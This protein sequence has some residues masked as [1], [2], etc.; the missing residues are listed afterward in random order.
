[1][2]PFSFSF[3]T[4]IQPI[5]I[6]TKS[7]HLSSPLLSRPTA[8]LLVPWIITA[9]LHMA[10]LLPHLA[11]SVTHIKYIDRI[12]PL[13]KLI[14]VFLSH[15]RMTHW[16]LPGMH[17][18]GHRVPTVHKA[19]GLALTSSPA[20][21][22]LYSSENCRKDMT[23]PFTREVEVAQKCM[24]RCPASLGIEEKQNEM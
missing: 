20:I 11:A 23:G 9:S 5:R 17:H 10:S 22:C 18:G 14:G 16:C 21:F 19:C 1:M 15:S 24:D 7:S 4:H 8:L 6:Y 12:S 3:I 2:T 13:L